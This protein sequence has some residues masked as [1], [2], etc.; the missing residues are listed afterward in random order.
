MLPLDFVPTAI[1]AHFNCSHIVFFDVHV[2]VK[3]KESESIITE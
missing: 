2:H 1:N 3:E